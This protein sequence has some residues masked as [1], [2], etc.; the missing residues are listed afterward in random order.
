MINHSEGTRLADKALHHPSPFFVVKIA[1]FR[2]FR[3][4]HRNHRKIKKSIDDFGIRSL[5]QS[6]CGWKIPSSDRF[7]FPIENLHIFHRGFS[8]HV[9]WRQMVDLPACRVL[10]LL[11]SPTVAQGFIQATH[12]KKNIIRIDEFSSVTV[13]QT[14]QL[15]PPLSSW[16][17]LVKRSTFHLYISCNG[18]STGLHS[19][20]AV[21]TPWAKHHGFPQM[22]VAQ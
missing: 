14:L 6:I 2:W 7:V 20:V 8:G 9:W 3:Y 1:I 21:E 15:L 22:G 5:G 17:L 13:F 12:N 19:D 10:L 11:Y 18:S 4:E 16:L